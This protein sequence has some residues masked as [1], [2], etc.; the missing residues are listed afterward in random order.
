M[1]LTRPKATLRMSTLKYK[2]PGRFSAA[3]IVVSSVLGVATYS[4][5]SFFRTNSVDRGGDSVANKELEKLNVMP[6][7]GAAKAMICPFDLS[8]QQSG[9][10][11]KTLVTGLP[12]ESREKITAECRWGINSA[13]TAEGRGTHVVFPQDDSDTPFVE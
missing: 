9:G 12:L 8:A 3:M 5:A 7:S 13:S 11:S 6:E 4:S 2:L 1:F 10:A